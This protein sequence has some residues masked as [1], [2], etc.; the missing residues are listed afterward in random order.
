MERRLS[1]IFAA[2]MVGYSRLIEADEI[3]TLERQKTHRIELIDP[4]FEEFHGRIVKEMGD[5]VLVEF[6]SVVEAVQC[7]VQIQRAMPVREAEVSNDR[8]I[9]YRIGINLGDIVVEDDDIYGDGVNV[10]AR[11]EALAEP[12]GIC[13]SGTTYDH[14]KAQ[15]EVGYE[16]LGDVK[17]KNLEHPVRAY[18]VLTDSVQK[19]AVVHKPGRRFDQRYWAAIGL[20]LLIAIG[21]GGWWWSQQP[22]FEPADP[23]KFAF[24]IPDKPSIAVLP[25]DNLSGDPDKEYLGDSL[26]E[27]I[28]AELATIPE[29]L[30]IARNSVM[31]YKGKPT[32]V[33]QVAEELGVQYV[34][35]GSVQTDDD[36]MRVVAQLVDALDGKHLWAERYDYEVAD[37]FA[38]QDDITRKLAEEMEVKLTRGEQARERIPQS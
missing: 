21:A 2:D 3:G 18:K 34:L 38:V 17:V 27:N 11:L 10:A 33:Q 6:P 16:A 4:A 31:T 26:T 25:F 29:M 15:V 37:I 20:V 1:A 8:K 24:E 35:E 28:I 14:L 13:I 7:A 22:D 19:G 23:E 36:K 9:T 12:G 5:G 32:K 30:I